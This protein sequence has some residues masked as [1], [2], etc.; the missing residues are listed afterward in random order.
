MAPINLSDTPM[1]SSIYVTSISL[2]FESNMANPFL[3][4][5][6]KAP[7]ESTNRYVI[8]LYDINSSVL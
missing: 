3:V 8:L 1:S 4:P 2:L 6:N 5:I 7:L